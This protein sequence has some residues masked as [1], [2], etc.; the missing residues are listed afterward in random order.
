MGGPLCGIGQLGK[1][2]QRFVEIYGEQN[3]IQ[4]GNIFITNN[5]YCGGVTHLNDVGGSVHGSMDIKATEI[6]QEDLRLPACRF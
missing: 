6:L 1:A 5:Q 3:V 2:V 4:E